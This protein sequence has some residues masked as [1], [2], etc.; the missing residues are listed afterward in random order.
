MLR[1]VI[2]S[3]LCPCISLPPC[4]LHVVLRCVLSTS[5]L[6]AVIISMSLITA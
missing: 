6:G 2:L 3:F 5:S 4:P 1:N